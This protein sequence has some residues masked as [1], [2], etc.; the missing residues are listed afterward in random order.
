L[1]HEH[2]SGPR[3]LELELSKDTHR[4]ILMLLQSYKSPCF[5]WTY[6]WPKSSWTLTY[7]TIPLIMLF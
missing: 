5:T 7:Y 4:L 2:N 1:T 6:F 3:V